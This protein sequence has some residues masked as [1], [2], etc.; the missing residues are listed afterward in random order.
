MRSLPENRFWKNVKSRLE[1][2]S[3]EPDDSWDVIAGKISVGG[4]D[5]ANTIGHLFSVIGLACF[6]FLIGIENGGFSLTSSVAKKENVLN[7]DENNPQDKKVNSG[8]TA[9]E[10]SADSTAYGSQESDFTAE[11]F[12]EKTDV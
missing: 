2:Y 3:E 12:N 5:R 11:A 8:I 1:N 9:G 7:S 6:L 4:A 10:Q